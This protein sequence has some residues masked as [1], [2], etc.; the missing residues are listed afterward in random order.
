MIRRLRWKFIAIMTT[1]SALFLAV[2]LF[3][4]YYSAEAGFERR[5]MGMLQTAIRDSHME[6]EAAPSAL[7]PEKR[8]PVLVVEKSPD[9]SVR[10]IRSLALLPDDQE[11]SSLVSR[12]DASKADWGSFSDQGLRWLKGRPE[13]DGAVRYAFTDIY[14]EQDALH[15]QLIRSLII[16]AASLGI[17]FLLS[18]L[19]SR[20]STRPI[21]QAWQA[22]QQFVSDASHELKT[23]LTVILANISLLKQSS[24]LSGASA[25]DLQRIDHIAS[26]AGRMKQLTE[27]LLQLARSD[28]SAG[29]RPDRSSFSPVDLT[30]LAESSIATF[31]PVAFEMGKSIS[32]EICENIQVLGD[33]GKLRQLLS[34]LLDNGCKYGKENSSVLVRLDRDGADAALTVRSEGT[35]FSPEELRQLFHRFYRADPS[36]GAVSGF[37]LGLSIARCICSEHGGKISAST[38]GTGTNTFTVRLP[39]LNGQEKGGPGSSLAKRLG[40]FL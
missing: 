18:V 26:E 36:R 38:D 28:N 31:E 27:R 40:R 22:Q 34:I 7:P 5:S 19:L 37:G 25:P 16:G 33:E 24:C 4:L 9:G 6:P 14:P 21:E 2:I 35:P 11:V 29:R 3:M 8:F 20:W 1:V 39:L 10:I 17:F 12:A 15:G 30:Y 32:G 23:P 13:P